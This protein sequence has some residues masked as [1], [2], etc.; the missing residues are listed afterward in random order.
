MGSITG[1]RSLERRRYSAALADAQERDR[2]KSPRAA[3]EVRCEEPARVVLQE[4]INARANPSE[5][6]VLEDAVG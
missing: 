3:I 4:R 1:A 2:V 5:Q 6:M